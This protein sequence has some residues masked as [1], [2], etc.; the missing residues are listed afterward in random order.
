MKLPK[1][2]LQLKIFIGLIL[3]IV[4]GLLAI[5]WDISG[6]THDW[7]KPW[8]TI[9]I[10]LLKLIAIPLI[11]VSLVQGIASM[12]NISQLSRLGYKTLALY[13]TTTV[14]AISVG[15]TVVNLIKPAKSFPA[16]RKEQLQ[17]IYQDQIGEV[18]SSVSVKEKTP[19]QVIVDIVP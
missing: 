19:I 2:S 16:D 5:Y 12:T 4:Y 18:I 10:R 3:G 13:V 17:E 1:I 14:I 15:L 7:I 6:F 11:F 8:G 9:F